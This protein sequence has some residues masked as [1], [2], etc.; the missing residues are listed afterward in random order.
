MGRRVHTAGD[1]PDPHQLGNRYNRWG[2]LILR[3]NFINAV[4]THVVLPMVTVAFVH[5]T[6]MK[7]HW[8]FINKMP[9][10]LADKVKKEF[11]H[12]LKFAKVVHIQF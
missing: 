10:Q 7:L 1:N 5:L 3:R 8:F 9:L 2:S 6:I 12:R 11:L 4:K